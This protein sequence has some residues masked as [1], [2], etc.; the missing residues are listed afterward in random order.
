VVE[1]PKGS[2]NKYEHDSATNRFYLDR[3]ALLGRPLSHRLWIYP[4]ACR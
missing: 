3:H 1:I 2:H 4:G